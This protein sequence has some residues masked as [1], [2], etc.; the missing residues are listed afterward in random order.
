MLHCHSVRKGKKNGNLHLTCNLRLCFL[1]LYFSL[2]LWLVDGGAWKTCMVVFTVN[3]YTVCTFLYITDCKGFIN[4]T[5]RL[6]LGNQQL[7]CNQLQDYR[8]IFN[9]WNCYGSKKCEQHLWLERNE[10]F[11]ILT[12]Q[13]HLVRCCNTILWTKTKLLWGFPAAQVWPETFKRQIT[14]TN[15]NI[16]VTVNALNN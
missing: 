8:I 10:C 7:D 9:N 16:H 2:C 5:K 11:E 3:N 12:G 4:K 6:A 1:F 15:S 14:G 13:V